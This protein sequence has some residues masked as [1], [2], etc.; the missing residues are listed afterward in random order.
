[1]VNFRVDK[2]KR[3]DLSGSGGTEP[4]AAIVDILIAPTSS[5]RT[6]SLQPSPASDESYSEN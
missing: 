2:R 6:A 4:T 5:N 3:I 1:L